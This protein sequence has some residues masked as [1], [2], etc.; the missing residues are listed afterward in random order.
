M[1][2]YLAVGMMQGGMMNG[3]MGGGM[4]LLWSLFFDSW[5]VEVNLQHTERCH[6]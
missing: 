2:T 5:A 4:L 3:M 6:E 1:Q